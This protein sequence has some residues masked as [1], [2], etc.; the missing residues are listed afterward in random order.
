VFLR[1][2]RPPQPQSEKLVPYIPARDYNCNKPSNPY[3]KSKQVQ[4]L[5][6]YDVY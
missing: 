6:L 5:Y 4:V 3:A 2:S 1:V